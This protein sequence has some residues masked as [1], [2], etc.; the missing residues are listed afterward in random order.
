MPKSAQGAPSKH[1]RNPKTAP[2][3]LQDRPKT[4]QEQ[5]ETPQERS[6]SPQ[7]HP[8][9][10]P[11][12]HLQRYSFKNTIRRK[13][14][15]F[16]RENVTFWPQD[17]PQNGSNMCQDPSPIQRH[18]EAVQEHPESSEER[19]KRSP[20]DPKSVSRATRRAKTVPKENAG[21][22]QQ[23][24]KRPSGPSRETCPSME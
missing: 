23:P 7:E 24:H 2:T 6:K 9:R 20:R 5:P 13:T 11:S 1:P 15:C 4:I 18:R 21:T 14:L 19:P 12:R 10:N 8:E 16:P 3:P 22:D 17:A